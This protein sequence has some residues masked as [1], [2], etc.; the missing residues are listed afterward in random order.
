MSVGTLRAALAVFD[1][2]ALEALTNK[3]IVRRAAKDVEGGKVTII[4]EMEARI[5]AA[6]DGETVEV[7]AGGPR[8]ARCSCPAA[9]ICRHKVAVVLA[10]RATAAPVTDGNQDQGS[11]EREALGADPL[12]E[13]MALDSATIAKW[14][15]K[16]NL[17]AAI[18]LLADAAAP[19]IR[20]DG[21][22]VPGGAEH[23]PAR[24]SRA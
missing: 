20:R 24:R 19:Q 15:G 16:P 9:G 21:A 5:V 17:R 13:V 12:A 4:E 2:A 3:G 10:F 11:Q 6:A 7:D 22:D 8:K 1:D 14:A 23:P 18:E